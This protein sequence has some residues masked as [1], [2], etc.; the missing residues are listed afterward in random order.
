MFVL[1]RRYKQRYLDK[2]AS[3]AADWRWVPRRGVCSHLQIHCALPERALFIPAPPPQRCHHDA[4]QR[5]VLAQIKLQTI[6]I[7]GRS[8][9]SPP[10]HDGVRRSSHSEISQTNFWVTSGGP[11]L[12]AP[13]IT[14][15][16]G[17]PPPEKDRVCRHR[18][19]PAHGG[20]RP[21]SAATAN[22]R[23]P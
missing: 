19:G 18:A 10:L 2:A 6:N 4:H 14:G 5:K 7:F 8:H 9:Q 1:A 21:P 23:S 17:P 11:V 22:P 16:V 13:E 20:Q 3:P 12:P 15:P